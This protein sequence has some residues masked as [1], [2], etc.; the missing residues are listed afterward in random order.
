[1]WPAKFCRRA[2]TGTK[3]DGALLTE[4]YPAPYTH[5]RRKYPNVSTCPRPDIGDRNSRN[6]NNV[7]ADALGFSPKAFG[8]NERVSPPTTRTRR[9]LIILYTRHEVSQPSS[10]TYRQF[11]HQTDGRTLF[12][13]RPRSLAIT[14]IAFRGVFICKRTTKQAPKRRRFSA[15]LENRVSYPTSMRR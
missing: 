2:A 8:A 4:P 12:R 13:G 6:N 14:G 9:P 3:V 1:M 11:R 15:G 7:R 5:R 10:G